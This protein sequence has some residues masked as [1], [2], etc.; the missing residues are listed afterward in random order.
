MSTFVCP[1][2]AVENTSDLEEGRVEFLGR[3]QHDY[4]Y[5]VADVELLINM[6]RVSSKSF[7]GILQWL[8]QRI[9]HGLR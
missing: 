5:C 1:S 8:R 2:P 7:V 6:M 9:R 3:K 4:G